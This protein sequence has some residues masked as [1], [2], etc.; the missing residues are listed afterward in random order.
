[1]GFGWKS[2]GSAPTGAQVLSTDRAVSEYGLTR[3]ELNEI[4]SS[5]RHMHGNYY[6]VWNVRDLSAYREEK[7]AKLRKLKIE[8]DENKENLLIE[9]FGVEGLKRKR[10]EETIVKNQKREE[11]NVVRNQK[12]KEER[13]I[14]NRNQNIHSMTSLMI[15]IRKSLG[16]QKLTALTVTPETVLAKP[17]AKEMFSLTD[18]KLRECSDLGPSG[19]SKSSY[20]V[21]D[22]MKVASNDSP[23]FQRLKLEELK[24]NNPVLIHEAAAGYSATLRGDCDRARTLVANANVAM[25]LAQQ[26][27]NSLINIANAADIDVSEFYI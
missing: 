16:T 12:N 7:R 17:Q 1:M 22:L 27:E 11:E 3:E 13:E 5:G 19:R 23:F 18:G 8:E 25:E 15:A 9:E 26:N 10:E 20:K 24:E 6:P 14:A 4:E 2:K 21:I